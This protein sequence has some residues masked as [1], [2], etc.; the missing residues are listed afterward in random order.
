MAAAQLEERLSLT[1][2]ETAFDIAVFFSIDNG[3]ISQAMVYR[4]GSASIG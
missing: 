3:L 1:E 2:G 4:E